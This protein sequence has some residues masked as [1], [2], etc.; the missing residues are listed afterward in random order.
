VTKSVKVSFVKDDTSE[1]E[2]TAAPSRPSATVVKVRMLAILYSSRSAKVAAR[3]LE[4]QP[5]GAT[6]GQEHTS[7]I[8]SGYERYGEM[9][10]RTTMRV[11]EIKTK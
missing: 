1:A 7:L 8:L 10:A 11:R 4:E 3:E 5:D 9:P 2:A 6:A